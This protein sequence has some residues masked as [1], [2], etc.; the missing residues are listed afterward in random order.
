MTEKEPGQEEKVNMYTD[1][2]K[3]NGKHGRINSPF[4][5]KTRVT[6]SM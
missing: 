5:L 1:Y 6:T 2:S 4:R 3:Q